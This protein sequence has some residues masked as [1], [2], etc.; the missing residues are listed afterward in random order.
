MNNQLSLIP[1]DQLNAVSGGHLGAVILIL[2][3]PHIFMGIREFTNYM[4]DRIGGNQ[5]EE[6][7]YF[8]Q[9]FANIYNYVTA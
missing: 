7:D 5:I 1:N 2:E 9:F 3:L 4:G 8:T 6:D